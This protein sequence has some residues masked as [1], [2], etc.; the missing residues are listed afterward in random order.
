MKYISKIRDC[1]NSHNVS[2]TVGTHQ[3]SIGSFGKHWSDGS[4]KK[5]LCKAKFG[6]NFQNIL[7][8]FC[9]KKQVEIFFFVRLQYFCL[10]QQLWG[11]DFHNFKNR[12]FFTS[13]YIFLSKIQ[14]FCDLS[15][16]IFFL[17]LALLIKPR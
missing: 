9:Q 10:F 5:L 2:F 16:S 6:K 3:W 13:V 11:V 15:L 12:N 7:Q 1:A 14:I 17:T 8:G 4:N